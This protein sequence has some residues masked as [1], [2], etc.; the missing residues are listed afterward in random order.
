MTEAR[1]LRI[2]V[3]SLGRRGGVPEYGW[4]MTK[5][6]SRHADVGVI[7]SAFAEN[8][9]KWEALD[10]PQLAVRTISGLTSLALSFFAFGRFAAI[11]RFAREFRPD[12]VYYPGGHVWK[13]LL[14]LLLPRSAVTVVTVHDPHLH[15]GEDSLLWRLLDW[16]NRLRASGFVLLNQSQHA[17]FVAR[18]GLDPSRVAVIPHGLFDDYLPSSGIGPDV[19]A[20]AG[21]NET[22]VGRYLL[23]AGR[24]RRYKGL[25]TLLTAYA[26]LATR[27][28]GTLVIAGSGE[29][30]EAENGQLRDLRGRPVHLVN[31]WLSDPEIAA[32]VSAARFVILPYRS[33]TQS[34]VVPMASALGI[35]AIASATGGLVEQVVDGSTG[36]LFPPED[37]AALQALLARAY[38]MGDAEYGRMSTQCREHALANWAWDGLSSQLARFCESLLR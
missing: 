15:A 10:C 7:Y 34:G 20:I 11:R 6:L 9:D 13:P 4:L 30:T 25:D 5:A 12:V 19:T 22:D 17:D 18:F 2:L 27:D 3:V 1:R 31:R 14:D 23:F 35:P 32:L 37:A 21:V 8:R 24:I 29:L 36:L 28:A 38:A 33:A 26:A 16:S